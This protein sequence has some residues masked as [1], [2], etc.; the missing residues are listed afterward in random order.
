MQ[1]PI[2]KTIITLIYNKKKLQQ[3]HIDVMLLNF[4]NFNQPYHQ[5]TSSPF[6][7]IPSSPA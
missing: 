7:T 4:H 6:P 1:F 2:L 3:T 5:G